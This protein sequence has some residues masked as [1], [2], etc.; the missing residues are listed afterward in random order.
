MGKWY[1][2]VPKNMTMET[3]SNIML[4]EYTRYVAANKKPDRRPDQAHQ[5]LQTRLAKNPC[6]LAQPPAQTGEGA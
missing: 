2:G 1:R 4:K 6:S 5:D 3:A